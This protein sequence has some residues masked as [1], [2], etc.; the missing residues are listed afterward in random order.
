MEHVLAYAGTAGV[1]TIGYPRRSLWLIAGALFAYS[2]A[3]WKGFR[4][5]CRGGIQRSSEPCGAAPARSSEATSP[6]IFGNE[7]HPETAEI[8]RARHTA[9]SVSSAGAGSSGAGAPPCEAL[10]ARAG[11]R[12]G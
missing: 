1:M 8:S 9:A 6:R 10:D 2:G 7:V 3:F 11:A 5:L 12:G 4:P